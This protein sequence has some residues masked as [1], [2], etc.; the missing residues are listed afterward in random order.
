MQQKTLNSNLPLFLLAISLIALT[1]LFAGC[2]KAKTQVSDTTAGENMEVNEADDSMMNDDM[3]NDDMMNDDMMNDDMMDDDMMDDDMM[4]DDMMND[5]MMDDQMQTISLSG[6]NF[7]FLMNGEENPTLR[8]KKGQKVSL[9]FVSDSGFHDFVVDE[10]GV[11]TDR[12]RD[13]EGS[14]TVEFTP[15]KTGTFEYY[16]SV[17]EHR[18]NGMKGT[19]IVE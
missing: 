18:A 19:I 4:N 13:G 2:T 14:T 17:G 15:E 6:K 1:V 12:V 8:V 3:M 16:C 11:A 9:E 7:A 5:D 10:L